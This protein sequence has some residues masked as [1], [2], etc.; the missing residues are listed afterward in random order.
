MG[1][2]DRNLWRRTSIAESWRY[3]WQSNMFEKIWRQ[4]DKEVSETLTWTTSK[5]KP[6]DKLWE[7]KKKIE[8]PFCPQE[9]QTTCKIYSAKKNEIWRINSRIHSKISWK[10]RALWLWWRWWPDPGTHIAAY[11]WWKPCQEDNPEEM[12]LG[13]IYRRSW[14]TWESQYRSQWHEE[15]V[16]D[17]QGQAE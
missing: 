2:V 17:K 11:Q 8:P 15:R 12:E 1:R 16:H 10:S 4:R 6:R 13:A 7:D 14:W 9:K 3:W 5:S